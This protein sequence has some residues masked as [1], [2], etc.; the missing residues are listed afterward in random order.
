MIITAAITIVLAAQQGIESS[1]PPS[2]R[3]VRA[4]REA[5][6]RAPAAGAKKRL[7]LAYYAAGQHLLF[8]EKMAEVIALDT[9]DFEPHYLLGRHYDSDVEDFEKAAAHFR[10]ALERN[11]RHAPSHAF[12]GHS[13]E[14]SAR[15]GAREAYRRAIE[16][17]AC[18]PAALAGLARMGGATSQQL[19]RCAGND[20]FLLEAAAKMLS[21][22]GK[23]AGAAALL[24]RAL[25]VD[26]TN[27][28]LAYQLHRA[29]R[30][31]AD[32]AK[33]R[34]A[35]AVY[36]RLNRIYGGR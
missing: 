23:H 13:L 31:A 15:E 24:A 25:A 21:T 30:A 14:S 3:A 4:A 2:Y 32:E 33:A 18:E 29:W 34:E 9:T 22:E 17:N 7:G 27:A 26:R 35:L 19:V 28:P 6:R 20:A 5:E 11:P 16:L 10:A 8:R 12:L 1:L 36:E